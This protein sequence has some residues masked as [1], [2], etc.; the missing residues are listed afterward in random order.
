MMPLGQISRPPW[1]V[2]AHAWVGT[3]GFCQIVWPIFLLLGPA[4]VDPFA[5]TPERL[6]CWWYKA[7]RQLGM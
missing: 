1:W 2:A 3:N 5:E 4:C 7:V 6:H